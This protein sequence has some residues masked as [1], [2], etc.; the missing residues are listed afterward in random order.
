MAGD[1]LPVPA[2]EPARRGHRAFLLLFLAASAA[3][4]VSLQRQVDPDLFWHLR[5]GL[6]ILRSERIVLPESW[7][8]LFEGR[9]WVNQQWATEVLFYSAF[10]WG[11]YGGL[12][13]LKGLLACAMVLFA[14]AA[15]RGRSLAVR[16]L[17]AGVF[18]G[19]TLHY[20]I[21]RTHLMSLLCTAVL[22]FLLERRGARD[23]LPW[24]LLLF[25]L[26][27]NL[28]ALFGLG[29]LILGLWVVVRWLQGRGRFNAEV[30]WDAASVPL[31]CA[32]TLANPFGW[33]V[34]QTAFS[35]LGDPETKLVTEWWPIW[36]HSLDQNLGFLFLVLL[37]AA[38]ALLFPR[39]VHWPS[40]AASCAIAALGVQ[41]VRFT[42]DVALP[43]LPL[44][45][46]L[47]AAV[48]EALGEAR[49][50]RIVCR[51]L[52]VLTGALVVFSAAGFAFAA[53]TPLVTPGDRLRVDY[54]VRAVA[55]MKANAPPGRIFNEYAWGGY[56]AWELPRCRTFIDPRTGVLLFPR[57]F[58][59]EWK[60]AVETRPGWR[61]T[62]ERGRP[63][64][65]LVLSDNYIAAQLTAEPGWELLFRDNVSVLYGRRAALQKG[66]E[67]P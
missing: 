31:A 41:H 56:L 34:W 44:L 58:V 10:R 15:L 62:L 14:L 11:G 50:Q 52:P 21:F 45:G 53:A 37:A 66:K 51:V 28:H 5:G 42:S 7:N 30:L 9:P 12:L 64:Y 27:A 63:D 16:F 24:V 49:T 60:R 19:T 38:L 2:E 13:V 47:L 65:V 48:E 25:A 33:G 18:V 59:G 43:A 6:D 67:H 1:G 8:Y 17:C 22:V 46:S 3:A 29:L 54:P 23:R 26:W 4:V 40:L 39:R 35:A 55:W 20:F 61:E 32:A 36:R 57:G